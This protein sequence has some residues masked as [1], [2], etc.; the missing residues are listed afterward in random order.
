MKNFP[1]TMKNFPKMF[2]MALP[3]LILMVPDAFAGTTSSTGGGSGAPGGTE[4]QT[5]WTTLSEWIQGYL[6]R[7]IAISFVVVGLAS[8]ILRGSVFG[9]V[10]G[11]ASG[12]GLYLSPTII[13]SIMGATLP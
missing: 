6:G 13:S 4:F 12:I 11:I 1:K 7:I 9:F 5:L 10:L 3:L 2:L 8:G